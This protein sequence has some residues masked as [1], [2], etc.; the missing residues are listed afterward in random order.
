MKVS[1]I[2][3]G[4]GNVKSVAFALERLGITPCITDNIDSIRT[5][6]KVIFPGVGEASSAMKIL[7]E[8]KLDIVIPALSQPVLGICLGM[9]LMCSHSEEG[10]T[11]ALNI[12]DVPV[13]LFPPEEKVPHTGWNKVIGKTSLLPQTNE[14]VYMYFVHS[15]F[16]P[17]CESTIASTF[18]SIEFSGMLQKNNFYGCQFHPEKSGKHGEY[19]LTKFLE[20]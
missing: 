17:L 8:K 13:K 20:L 19:I 15:Y 6:D 16:V 11:Q 3:Y 2:N 14:G 18:Y 12:F 9:Q 10:N 1:I 7:K 4:A 5:A